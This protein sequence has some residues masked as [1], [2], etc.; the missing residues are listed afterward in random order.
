MP[1]LA[2]R[3]IVL[4][5]GRMRHLPWRPALLFDVKVRERLSLLY[6]WE[7]SPLM[8]LDRGLDHHVSS[9]LYSEVLHHTVE[10]PFYVIGKPGAGASLHY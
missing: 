5:V 9:E 7:A 1:A 10:I 8:R 2:T 3:F 6:F 4:L